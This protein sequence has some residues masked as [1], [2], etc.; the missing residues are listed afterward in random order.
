LTERL[1]DPVV[2]DGLPDEAT[3]VALRVAYDGARY[4]GFAY[5]PGTR[6]VAGDLAGALGRM[7]GRPVELT[8]AGR[9][10]AGV[11]ALGQVVHVD[12][13]TPFV[14]D[15]VATLARSLTRQLGPSVVVTG[16]GVAPAGF[17][18][19]RSAVARRY[20]YLVLNA[21]FPDP[22]LAATSWHVDA[23]LDV[24]AMRLGADPLLGDHDF[25]AFCRRPRGRP[26]ASLRRRV[27][28]AAWSQVPLPC[29]SADGFA[30][31]TQPG[32]LLRFDM[33]AT[34]FCQQMVRSV[35]AALVAV[36]EG[37]L[38]AGDMLSILRRG[39]RSGLP[40][41]APPE[42]LCLLEVSYPPAVAPCL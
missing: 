38:R 22:L 15:H 33:E 42:G 17:D 11:H 23:P 39:D 4:H 25:S 2:V 36:G 6:T 41:V 40:T 24:A 9:T 3:R 37:R 7:A 26:E 8:C 16:A 30:A 31:D 34:S 5:Q 19:R 18:A 20:R 27:L 35:V 28:R 13:P 12:L 29:E 21:P 10:D 14:E 1:F 32:A